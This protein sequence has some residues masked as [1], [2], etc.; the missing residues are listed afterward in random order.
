L[1]F[2]QVVVTVV[3]LA[4]FV[5]RVPWVVPVL[6]LLLGAAALAG[7]AANV[8]GRSY[9][10]L[11]FGRTPVERAAEPPRVTRITRLVETGLL[12]AASVVFLL[13]ADGFAWA[14]ALPVAAI[15]GLAATT[16]INLVAL[17]LERSER[18]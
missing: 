16:G 8:F 1:R 15:T 13:G 6:A 10:Y 7:P 5:F 11:F 17:V 9:A 12:L 3:L 2:E 18:R 4:G 14:L